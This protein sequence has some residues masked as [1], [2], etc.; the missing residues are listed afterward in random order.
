MGA[1]KLHDILESIQEQTDDFYTVV[2]EYL[3]SIIGHIS[4]PLNKGI[5]SNLILT[6]NEIQ[7]IAKICEWN[8]K[9]G[10][11]RFLLG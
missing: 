5:V 6:G 2:E 1:L 3:D 10:G 9:M 7:L 8:R 11:T 4:I